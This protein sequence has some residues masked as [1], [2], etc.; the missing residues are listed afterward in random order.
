MPA[1][2]SCWNT[3]IFCASARVMCVRESILFSRT[4]P[5]RSFPFG[6]HKIIPLGVL[7]SF[8]RGII[9]SDREIAGGPLSPNIYYT[10]ESSDRFKKTR[11]FRPT[12]NTRVELRERGAQRGLSCWECTGTWQNNLFPLCPRKERALPPLRKER[13]AIL[14]R[15]KLPTKPFSKLL[16]LSCTHWPM[17]TETTP[18]AAYAR[19]NE[20]HTHTEREEHNFSSFSLARASP[21]TTQRSACE[22]H[23]LGKNKKRAHSLVKTKNDAYKGPPL[24][25]LFTKRGA[26][27]PLACGKSALESSRW[28]NTSL[29]LNNA[30]FAHL[31]KLSQ[32]ELRIM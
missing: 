20:R 3:A 31:T 12:R 5:T 9:S 4:R 21:P 32:R 1:P 28:R 11:H 16:L 22:F 25:A 29:L 14:K 2:C 19:W 27:F 18:F 26:Y 30:D 15:C 6:A 13:M 17:S 24:L 23:Y 10:S 7:N 8:S